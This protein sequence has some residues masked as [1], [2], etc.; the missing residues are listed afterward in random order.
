M[1]NAYVAVPGGQVLLYTN[2]ETSTVITL[3]T[4]EDT[5]AW[6]GQ[7]FVYGHTPRKQRGRVWSPEV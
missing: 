5:E 1:A 2:V 7:G 4:I 3:F 6:K